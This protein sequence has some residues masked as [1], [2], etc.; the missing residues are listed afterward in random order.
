LGLIL[1]LSLGLGIPALIVIVGSLLYKSMKSKR[2]MYTPSDEDKDGIQMSGPGS[3][4]DLTR[5]IF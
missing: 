4:E 1:G 3:D 2:G 5:H